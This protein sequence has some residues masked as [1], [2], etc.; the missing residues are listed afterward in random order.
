[1][2]TLQKGDK[3]EINTNDGKAMFISLQTY[4]HRSYVILFSKFVKEINHCTV[5]LT[6]PQTAICVLLR[7]QSDLPKS[8][9]WF[10]CSLEDRLQNNHN[11]IQFEPDPA[12]RQISG[13]KP[14]AESGW[15]K[16]LALRT[17]LLQVLLSQEVHCSSSS[18]LAPSLVVVRGSFLDPSP[19]STI[20][21]PCEASLCPKHAA[22]PPQ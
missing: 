2:D 11:Q 21:T 22:I 15:M 7:W 17:P 14:S 9:I 18:F 4:L 19:P 13:G 10:G 1:M 16:Q 6:I 8:V 12:W 3:V 5:Y 20:I